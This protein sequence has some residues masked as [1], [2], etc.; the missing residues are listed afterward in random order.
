LRCSQLFVEHGSPFLLKLDVEGAEW[1]CVRALRRIRSTCRPRYVVVEASHRID[2][3]LLVR[4]G[5]DSF[6]WVNQMNHIGVWGASSGPFGEFGV[7]CETGYRWRN[8]SNTSALITAL[9][10]D[11]KPQYQP[12]TLPASWPTSPQAAA[13]RRRRAVASRRWCHGWADLH[14]RHSTVSS[15]A[16]GAAAAKSPT[17]TSMSF[18][19]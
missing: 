12:T 1:P 3:A 11:R 7:D 13:A 4:L 9:F 19:P 17:A 14:A 5:Y 2:L 15:T 6:K 8:A 18:D 10:E 16:W